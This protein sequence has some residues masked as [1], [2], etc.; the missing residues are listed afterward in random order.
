MY[1]LGMVPIVDKS[2]P[3]NPNFDVWYTQLLCPWDFPSDCG[4]SDAELGV[5]EAS[6]QMVGLWVHTVTVRAP[7]DCAHALVVKVALATRATA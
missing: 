6:G 1:S 7:Y 4:A 2:Q 5:G 3:N